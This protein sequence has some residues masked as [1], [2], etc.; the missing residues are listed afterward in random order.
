MANKE[1]K[2]RIQ[3]IRNSTVILEEKNPKTLNGE[4]YICKTPDTNITKFKIGDGRYFNEI[5][6][7]EEDLLKSLGI[8][9]NDADYNQILVFNGVSGK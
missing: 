8:E 1:L 7:Y 2:T 4:F 5:P 3:L 9:I 6:Y